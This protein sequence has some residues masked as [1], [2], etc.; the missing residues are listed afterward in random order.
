[1]AG[2]RHERRR[3]GEAAAGEETLS[4][5]SIKN[6]LEGHG[7]VRNGRKDEGKVFV[8]SASLRS[9]NCRR[10][11]IFLYY[12]L[13]EEKE[14]QRLS[15]HTLAF[16]EDIWQDVNAIGVLLNRIFLYQSRQKETVTE[17]ISRLPR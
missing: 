8:A 1:M 17:T 7:C 9:I 10:K 16:V 2:R 12:L 3:A 11:F 6:V 4:R 14:D 15:N 5:R 13:M